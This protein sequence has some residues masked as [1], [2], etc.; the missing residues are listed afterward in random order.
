MKIL[1]N[2]YQKISSPHNIWLAWLDYRR[3]KRL[4]PA[5]RDFEYKLEENLT[6]LITELQNGTYHHGGYGKFIVRD[7]KQRVISCPLVRDHIVHRAIYNVLYPFFDRIFSPFSFSCRQN[8]GTHAAISFVHKYARQVSQNYSKDCWIL[9]GDVKKCFDSIDHEILLSLL[10]KR[11][12]CPETMNL[13]KKVIASY[14]ISTKSTANRVCDSGIPLGNLTSQLF[15]N[16]YLHELDFFVKEKLLIKHY[17]R[18]A[19]DFVAIFS[20]R[21][22]CDHYAQ[23]IRKFLK[24]ELLLDFPISHEKIHKLTRGAEMFGVKLLPF[25]YKLRVST[26]SRSVKLLEKRCVDHAKNN[27][28]TETLNSSWQS[29][30]GML[31][32]G[33]NIWQADK[34]IKL[35]NNHV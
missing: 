29:V 35:I 15:I 9:H 7:P 26:Y 22:S 14:K 12:Y 2:C 25:Y 4:K 32:W 18:Y 24:K 28:N 8:K 13:L 17:V 21:S 27:I 1:K 19:D 10:A 33:H 6:S 31:R 5:V 23:I 20:S 34:I 30:L 3:G 16:V 11:I